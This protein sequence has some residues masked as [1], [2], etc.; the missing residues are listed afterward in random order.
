MGFFSKLFHKKELDL[1]TDFE[2]N[3][4]ENKEEKNFSLGLERGA[5]PEEKPS[6][7]SYSSNL[8]EHSLKPPFPSSTKPSL[9]SRDFEL[10]NSKLD[11]LKAI[12]NNIEQR[13]ANLEQAAGIE[14]K[15]RLW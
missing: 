2:G 8:E 7:H 4:E 3:L 10:L 15:N 11:T 9:S 1:E 5:S 12:L 6:F 13:L 14:K